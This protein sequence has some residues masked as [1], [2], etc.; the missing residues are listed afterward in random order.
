MVGTLFM[1]LM[2]ISNIIN[3]IFAPIPF[4]R[5]LSAFAIAILIYLA[6]FLATKIL[7]KL[8]TRLNYAAAIKEHMQY[9]LEGIRPWFF[10]AVS[11]MIASQ[12]LDIPPKHR[13]LINLALSFIILIQ[14][15]KISSHWLR[16]FIK[17]LIN[18]K[19]FNG[20]NAPNLSLG[21]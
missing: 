16:F 8:I 11:I 13:H 14:V 1:D 3:N 7:N 20:Q 2:S 10:L 9:T 5:Y 4:H 15:L 19:S 6:L 21:A 12:S 17:R 18:S